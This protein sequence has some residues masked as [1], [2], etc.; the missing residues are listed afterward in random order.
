[1]I[2]THILILLMSNLWFRCFKSCHCGVRKSPTFKDILKQN[3]CYASC[4][5]ECLQ[6]F[7]PMK[8]DECFSGCSCKCN[9]VCLESC[10][11]NDNQFACR[12]SCG[13]TPT[14]ED[15]IHRDDPPKEQTKD[16]PSVKEATESHT[17]TDAEPK[18]SAKPVCTSDCVNNCLSTAIGK[19]ETVLCFTN[20]G[21]MPAFNSIELSM[22][23]PALADSSSSSSLLYLMFIL[24]LVG[25][26]V[27]TT[28]LLWD[29][30]TKK[31]S[32]RYDEESS[33]TML[34]ETL[35]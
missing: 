17:V 2:F 14:E 13:C 6:E 19:D 12:L 20:C 7:D 28:Y 34:Y 33:T 31:R 32:K 18:T 22:A 3:A 29:R 15:I 1:M 35:E 21:C 4:N 26:V 23:S 5:A 8:A 9:Q 25:I 10:E 27:G 11:D 30:D 16:T 24:F